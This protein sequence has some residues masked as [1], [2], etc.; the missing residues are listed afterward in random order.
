MKRL[1]VSFA[2][3]PLLAGILSMASSGCLS[4]NNP[5][6]PGSSSNADGG[7][8]VPD[9][10]AGCNAQILS[11]CVYPS[12]VCFEYSGPPVGDAGDPFDCVSSGGTL[13]DDGQGCVRTGTEGSCVGG[14]GIAVINGGPCTYYLTTW[15]P[16]GY[17]SGAPGEPCRGHPGTFVPN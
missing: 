1:S 10:G 4:S 14:A 8:L 16:G 6:G 17:D 13:N 11:R 2:L 15:L 3:A 12:G 7:S 5:S 9:S